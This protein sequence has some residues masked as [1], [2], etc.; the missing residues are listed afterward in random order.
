VGEDKRP[1]E[2]E[3]QVLSLLWR[4]G[5][6]TVRQVMENLP[7]GRKRAYTSVLSVMQVMEKKGFLTHTGEGNTHIYSP[8]L[9]RGKV[10]GEHMKRLVVQVFGGSRAEAVQQLLD[11]SEVTGEEIEEIKK[12][13]EDRRAKRGERN[14]G[15]AEGKGAGKS[16]KGK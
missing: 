16:S 8:V 10:L 1:S 12:L 13:L 15:R 3:L 6:K 5:P 4:G 9:S 14:M 11:E 2:L 7:D